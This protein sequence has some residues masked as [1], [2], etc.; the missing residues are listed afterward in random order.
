MCYMCILVQVYLYYFKSLCVWTCAICVCIHV[1]AGIHGVRRKCWIPRAR[2]VGRYEPPDAGAG[3]WTL[4]G[5]LQE[6]CLL[7]TT[8]SSLQAP[9]KPFKSIVG[10]SHLNWIYYTL[11]TQTQI[12]PGTPTHS[13]QFTFLNL[14]DYS[15]CFCLKNSHEKHSWNESK[16]ER[17][18]KGVEMKLWE[19]I[20]NRTSTL[21]LY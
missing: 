7:L 6:Q 8:K 10:W 4:V 3:N 5:P 14:P 1:C 18:R 9:V 20:G 2:D 12:S 13:Q 19:A 11:L 16:R 15:H 17:R 21:T